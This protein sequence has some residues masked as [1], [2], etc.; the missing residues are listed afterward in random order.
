MYFSRKLEVALK[1]QLKTKEI[2]VVTGMRRVGKTTLLRNL[3]NEIESANKAYLDI[4]NPIEQKIFEEA[5]YNNIWANLQEYGINPKEKSYLF[6]DEIQAKAD[7]VK[8][9]KYL[10][11]HYDVK[12]FLTG[13]SSFYLK[14]LFPESL[15]GR[16]IIFELFPL[17]FEE[18]LKFKNQRQEFAYDFKQKTVQKNI[19]N[20]EKIKNYYEDYLQYGGFP[21]IVLE[22]DENQ[23]KLLLTDI[24]KSYFELD[25][26]AL[27][28]FTRIN[29]FRDLLLL[30]LQRIGSK[31]DI[32]KLASEV[33]V[34]RETVYSYIAFL[35]STYFISLVSPFSTNKDREVSGAKK[36]YA[37]D[38][39]L[40]N[41]LSNISPGS[42]F[43][44][45]V[46]L[47]LRNYGN[48][49]YYQKYSSAEVDFILADK[50]IALE[51]KQTGTPSDYKRLARL[52]KSLNLSNYYVITKKFSTEE[53]FIPAIYV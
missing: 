24:F 2:I 21:Q 19:I 3:Y 13:S 16:K 20:Y 32:T 33:G 48:I 17:D 29:A 15:A 12:F 35:Q 14:N 36:V 26:K 45:A 8:A 5:D 10:Y 25:V 6:L 31:V 37:C 42:L 9:I 53:G 49:H 18:Y 38:S 28:D 11:D 43:E 22:K 50:K 41:H 47:N 1:K 44:N 7:I 27:A 4:E 46:Y 52:A 51:I 39:G 40:A 23:K 34:S 30:L